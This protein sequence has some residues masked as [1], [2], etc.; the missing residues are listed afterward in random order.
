[1]KQRLRAQVTLPAF[2]SDSLFFHLLYLTILR[3]GLLPHPCPIE[4]RMSPADKPKCLAVEH[5]RTA[6]DIAYIAAM[7]SY[8]WDE[9]SN[10]FHPA[11]LK[12]L[13]ASCLLHLFQ[14]PLTTYRI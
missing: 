9:V 4:A 12:H 14:V 3:L 13:G 1:M 5:P 2:E 7:S 6:Q 11:G 8:L 10:P